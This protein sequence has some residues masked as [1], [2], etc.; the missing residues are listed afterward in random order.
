MANIFDQFDD[1]GT[2]TATPPAVGDPASFKKTYGPAA[3]KAG[4][5]LGVDPD[6]IL[7]QWGL[8]TDWGK[9]IVPGTNNLGNIKGPNGVKAKDNQTG[10]TDSYRKYES[11]DQFADDY[12]RLIKAKY[13]GAVDAGTD[14]TKFAAALK[15]GGYAED[16]HYVPKVA[17]A[18]ASVPK[19]A[20]TPN[21]FDQFDGIT[22]VPSLPATPDTTPQPTQVQEDLRGIGLGTRATTAGAV[23]PLTS[24]GDLLNTGVNLGIKGV[25][26]LAGAA[27]SNFKVPELQLP[28]QV[29]QNALTTVGLPQPETPGERVLSDIQGGAAGA[30]TGAGLFGQAAKVATNPVVRNALTQLGSNVTAQTVSGATSAGASG[31]VRELG[32]GPLAQFVAGIAGGALPVTIAGFAQSTDRATRNAAA[33]LK[34]ALADN[35]PEE[36]NNAR[37]LLTE[38][39]KQG[40][41]LVGPE[42]FKAGSNVQ[43][44][45][46]QV[47]ASPQGEPVIKNALA[48]RNQ[49]VEDAA[50]RNVAKV[51]TNEGA[52]AAA[53][54]A[55]GAAENVVRNAQD[56]RTEAAG[57]YYQGQKASDREAIKLSDQLD[58][59]PGQIVD[60][61]KSANSATQVAGK[62]H[63]FV[64]DQINRMNQSIMKGWYNDNGKLAVSDIRARQA[65]RF[66]GT[67]DQGKGGVYDAIN[68]AKQFRAQ[69]DASQRQLDQAADQLAQKN[70]PAIQGKMNSFLSKL[71]NDIRLAG[72]T[73]E[74]RILK[75]YRDELAPG[76]KPLVL[77]S[78]LES[79]Y[80]ANRNKTT[81]N[82]NPTADERTAAGVLKDH[83]KSLDDLIK[84]VSPAIRAGREVYAQ[85]SREVVDPLLKSPVGRIAG[86]GADAQKESI[87]SRA[88]GELSGKNATPE[89]I[90]FLAD[91]LG[92]VDKQAFPNLV[93]SYLEQKLNG[94]LKTQRSGTLPSAGVNLRDALEGTPQERNNLRAMIQKVAEAQ[95]QDP[96]AAYEGFGR[97]LD[98]LDATGRLGAVKK[99]SN[100][101]DVAAQAGRMAADAA[102]DLKSAGAKTVVSFIR[103]LTRR[104]AYAKLAQVM[105]SPTAIDDM[106]ALANLKPDDPK[107]YQY[108]A[109]I[110]RATQQA[111]KPVYPDDSGD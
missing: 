46:N 48:Q 107:R 35:S 13:P 50:R 111:S 76:G 102:L 57:P 72:D 51:G 41:P 88:L 58:T 38:S 39:Q 80:K 56:Y 26:A 85:I 106:R 91:Q 103:D 63:A 16:A 93:R 77:P 6:V 83:V 11:P 49:Q 55:Q 64:N 67:A 73:T 20:P 36:W 110:I 79:V 40:V 21:A 62:L 94:A 7:G 44:L 75:Q 99:P 23:S 53:D 61:T 89:R 27:G 54:R 105:T 87:V 32:G 59:L 78:Q 12:V 60:L 86:R 24:L 98:V 17:A 97:F 31:T 18:S 109:S 15:T 9:K 22:D 14:A 45:A 82:M 28:S 34:K 43:D 95:G 3:E 108:A 71:D 101:G 19:S 8:E 100:A 96:S 29:V 69:L 66:E 68:R 47:F 84:D 74:G 90:G 42:A 4:K 81:L 25:N 5:E 92:Q 104:K 65:A 37:N 10:T 33:L 30:A 52:Q 2:A 1:G 70:L